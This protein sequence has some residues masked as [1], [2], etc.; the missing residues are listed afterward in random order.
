MFHDES[1]IFLTDGTQE[2]SSINFGV[3]KKQNI[4]VD[5][6]VCGRGSNWLDTKSLALI[7]CKRVEYETHHSRSSHVD[8]FKYGK[9]VWKQLTDTLNGLPR[10]KHREITQAQTCW[11]TI[12]KEYRNV[13]NYL[14]ESG[15]AGYWSLPYEQK[16]SSQKQRSS[17]LTS[18][19]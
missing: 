11:E 19:V 10:F 2:T 6:Q 1:I 7:D 18:L 3:G 14:D 8:T 9:V 15:F 17:L 4:S 12:R 5:K 13:K 16:K